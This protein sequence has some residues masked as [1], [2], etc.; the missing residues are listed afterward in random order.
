VPKDVAQALDRLA[1]TEDVRQV[2]VMPDVHLSRHVCTGTVV[3]TR[4]RLFP[5]AVGGDIGCGMAA[6]RFDGPASLLD[7][8]RAAARLLTGLYQTVP[9]MR[10]PRSTLRDRLPEALDSTALSHPGLEK[11]KRR[12]GRVQFAT[13]GRGNHFLEFQADVED[14]LWLMVHSGSRAM[15]QAITAY[16]LEDAP[17]S[18][19]G[20]RFLE[21]DSTAGEAYLH[22]LGWACR[23]ANASRQSMMEAVAT[24]IGELFDIS[25]EWQSVIHCNHNHVRREMC[26][27][28]D[29]WIHR[30]G[31]VSAHDGEPGIIPGSMGAPSFHVTGRGNIGALFSSS[32]GAGRQMSRS[33]AARAV[34]IGD[35]ER[36]MRGVWFDHRLANRLR[37]EAPSAY[38]DIRAV[39]RAQHDLTRIVRQLRPLLSYKGA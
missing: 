4:Q 26:A 33:E 2:A 32:H 30:K 37:D 8:E 15:G 25:A 29:L 6:L 5:Q 22:D 13:L 7:D 19:T 9:A 35:L 16:H 34:T 31:A 36:Q 27:G 24:L 23:Y 18:N 38:K 14:G 12:D 39:M 17:V 21:A 1:H 11:L 10:H 3:A 20:L 28:E